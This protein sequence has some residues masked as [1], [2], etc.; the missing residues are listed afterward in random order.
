M[1]D[2]PPSRIVR[3]AF[4]GEFSLVIVETTLAKLKDK[5]LRKRY[6]VERLSLETVADLIASLRTLAEIHLL[7]SEPLPRVVRDPRDD[8]LLVPAVLGRMDFVVSGDRDL[9]ALGEFHGVRM[10]TPVLEER[11][12]NRNSDL[13]G[14]AARSIENF[15]T[16]G[17]RERTP[18]KRT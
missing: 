11:M 10:V 17:S 1:S 9:L 2:N 12:G 5:V 15:M 8:Y 3:A 18:A 6:L 7:P 13:T 14:P 16:S 4:R